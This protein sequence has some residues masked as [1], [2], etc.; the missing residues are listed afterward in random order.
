MSIFV[1]NEGDAAD[2]GLSDLPPQTISL[3]DYAVAPGP[4]VAIG[5][6]QFYPDG[7]AIPGKTLAVSLQVSTRLSA[8][9]LMGSL[10]LYNVTDDEEA[11][12]IGNITETA[13]TGRS[14]LVVPPGAAKIYE[15]RAAVAGVGGAED[16]MIV[17]GAVL[18]LVWS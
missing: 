10:T 9:G 6:A 13:F 14:V 2:P 12:F 4:L 8:D 15:L 1:N 11:V 17:M 5:G 16:F 7:F 3:V 18:R